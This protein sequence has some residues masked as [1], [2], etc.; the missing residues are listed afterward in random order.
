M[1]SSWVSFKLIGVLYSATAIPVLYL[2]YTSREKRRENEIFLASHGSVAPE[3]ERQ[4]AVTHLLSG[5]AVRVDS[6][7]HFEGSRACNSVRKQSLLMAKGDVLEVGI[8]TGETTF[9]FISRNRSI[10]T[11]TGLDNHGIALNVCRMNAEKFANNSSVPAIVLVNARA[12]KLPFP[13]KSLDPV[14]AVCEMVRV[15][16]GRVILVEHGLSYWSVVRWLGYWTSLFPDPQ[17]PWSYGCYQN[18]DIL[19]ILKEAGVTVKKMQTSSLGHVYMITLAGNQENNQA[20]THIDTP[21]VV[22]RST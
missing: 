19:A 16:R 7:E 5:D 20:C 22:Y 9:T 6:N 3:S 2:R 21:N 14:A 8:G 11:Y 4:K 13:D 17:H 10:H 12:E 1:T 18:R 15:S